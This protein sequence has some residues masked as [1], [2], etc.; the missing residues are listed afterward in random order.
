MADNLHGC[1]NPLLFAER[2]YGD[3]CSIERILQ[4]SG[5]EV[6]L[7]SKLEADLKLTEIKIKVGELLNEFEIMTDEVN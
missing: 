5:K 7:I 3:L 2:I 4:E 1:K 6:E